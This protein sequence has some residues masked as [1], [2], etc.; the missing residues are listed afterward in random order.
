MFYLS[1]IIF[2]YIYKQTEFLCCIFL[3]SFDRYDSNPPTSSDSDEDYEGSDKSSGDESERE[4][5]P[6]KV[7]EIKPKEPK[8]SKTAK[9]VVSE[10]L[11]KI[12]FLNF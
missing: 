7:K 5:A 2:F 10:Q 9:T 12:K 1:W 8:K 3:Y 4:S 11:F 6:K